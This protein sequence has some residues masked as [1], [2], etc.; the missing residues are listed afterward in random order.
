[1]KPTRLC[2]SAAVLGE[3][4]DV[5]PGRAEQS[6]PGADLFRFVL[7]CPLCRR[8]VPR[9]GVCADGSRPM[10]ECIPCDLYFEAADDGA[11]LH[12]PDLA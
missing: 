8:P 12:G 10:A 6:G 1:M 5:I 2:A 9:P 7:D 11:Y 4:L 3:P